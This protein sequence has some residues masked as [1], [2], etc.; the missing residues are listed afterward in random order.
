MIHIVILIHIL[1]GKLKRAIWLWITYLGTVP[2][3]YLQQA[4]HGYEKAHFLPEDIIKYPPL[5][6]IL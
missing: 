1:K 6:L 5:T 3:T 4:P 2:L